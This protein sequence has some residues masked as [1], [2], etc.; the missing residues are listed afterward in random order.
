MP[1]L[2]GRH[3]AT[4]AALWMYSLDLGSQLRARSAEAFRTWTLGRRIS[5]G[6]E[7]KERPAMIVHRGGTLLTKF[8]PRC[9]LYGHLGACGHLGA[10]FARGG[11]RMCWDFDADTSMETHRRL[12]QI[13]YVAIHG[14]QHNLKGCRV[15][16]SGLRRLFLPTPYWQLFGQTP[17]LPCVCRIMSVDRSV[18]RLGHACR[19]V[20][21]PFTRRFS[22]HTRQRAHAVEQL[23]AVRQYF[24]AVGTRRVRCC[25]RVRRLHLLQRSCHGEG[26][27]QSV[28][29]GCLVQACG[30]LPGNSAKAQ[31][32][33]CMRHGTVEFHVVVISC[34]LRAA[35]A[36]DCQRCVA[37]SGAPMRLVPL[38]GE[39]CARGRALGS[40]W[41]SA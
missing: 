18:C 4:P 29:V 38:C 21:L 27:Q 13:R 11:F 34:A 32:A 36:S 41:R 16:Y 10:G 39:R 22:A 31:I 8:A 19:L 6:G 1:T 35:R 26:G 17:V 7:N 24:V 12:L 9:L 23:R 20:C 37:T 2:V 33:L 14:R 40:Q 15:G 25:F 3:S 30:G 5:I 28:I